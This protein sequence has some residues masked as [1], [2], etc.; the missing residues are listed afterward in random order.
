MTGHKDSGGI[1]K[2]LL[3]NEAGNT[4]AIFA[5]SI[6]P[7]IAIIGSGIELSRAYMAKTQLQAAC[8]A[9]AL[10]GRKAMSETREFN[11]TV[12]DRANTMFR[13]N[14]DPESF[15]QTQPTF[16]ASAD[17]RMNVSGVATLAMPT[18]IMNFFN[19]DEIDLTANCTAELQVANTDVMFVLDTTGSMEGTRLQGLR[20]AVRDFHLTLASADIQPE[21]RI[22][23]GFVPYS[24][25][26]NAGGLVADRSLPSSYFTNNGTYATR[27]GVFNTPVNVETS[28]NTTYGSNETNSSQITETACNTWA[29]SSSTTGTA[30]SDVVT[31]GYAKVS[32]TKGSGNK[33][34]TGTCIR[35]SYTTTKTYKVIWRFTRW[36]YRVTNIDTTGLSSGQSV[37]Y[38]S[39][40]S[41]GSSWVDTQGTYNLR[42]M[43]AMNDGVRGGS[44]TSKSSTWNGCVIERETVQDGTGSFDPIPDGARDLDIISAP[45][46]GIPGSYWQ[47][48]WPEVTWL[49]SGSQVSNSGDGRACPSP[50]ANFHEV[51]LTPNVVPD[52]LNTYV[53]G[54]VAKGF[55]YHDVGMTWGARLGSPNGIMSSIVN[56]RP[57]QPVNR[58]IVYMTDG[59]INIIGNGESSY[60]IEFQQHRIAPAGTDDSTQLE[61]I[62][63]RRFLAAC[64]EARNEGYTIWVIAFGL[65]LNN[66]LRNCASGGRAYTSN[67]TTELRE[68]FRNIATQVAD[69]RLTQ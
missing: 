66:S 25:T 54:F 24:M 65:P 19:F 45:Q 14:F 10:A 53:N 49:S 15:E 7:M 46:A 51:E 23:Y 68:T 16:T 44:M 8:D 5:A 43:A 26:T 33:T 50:M 59:A 2:S 47:V 1:L 3:A 21:T 30:P 29:V 18:I 39:S 55:T 40:A 61:E 20:D 35:R 13:A 6:V 38:V 63:T 56:D 34:T 11:Q 67:N 48:Q 41:T 60:G 17:E 64:R 12:R 4:L 58:H 28:N 37:S 9:G 31:R 69:L 36:D 27:V 22:R 62:H 32:W 42:Q 57:H 52:W